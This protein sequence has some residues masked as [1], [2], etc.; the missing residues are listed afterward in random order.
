MRL[1]V[2]LGAD[3]LIPNETASTP[4]MAACGVGSLAPE[5]EAGTEA[6]ALEAVE[7]CLAHG[8]KVEA[9]DL[10][11]ETAMHGA[12]YKSFP[13]VVEL[14]AAK[15]LRI[16]T[17]NHKTKWGWSPYDIASGHRVGNFNPSAATQV[18]IGRV[19]KASGVLVPDTESR[20]TE[21]LPVTEYPASTPPPPKRP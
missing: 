17:W 5:E 3:P 9:L 4:L 14:L 21:V 19:M 15:G 18:A 6:E 1:L 8:A 12:A 13:K 11:G 7:F 20:T 16:D 10:N 2:E